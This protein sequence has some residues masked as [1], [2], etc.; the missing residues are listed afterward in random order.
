MMT[1]EKKTQAKTHPSFRPGP[2]LR[3]P[4]MPHRRQPFNKRLSLRKFRIRALMLYIIYDE[5]NNDD[6]NNNKKNEQ[7]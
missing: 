6:D 3:T 1:N 5:H 2:G 7:R 4:L